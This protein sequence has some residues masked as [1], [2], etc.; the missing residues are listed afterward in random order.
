MALQGKVHKLEVVLAVVELILAAAAGL[1]AP[2]PAE[3]EGIMDPRQG[4][5][6]H[7]DKRSI[8]RLHQIMFITVFLKVWHHRLEVQIC[9]V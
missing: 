6:E 8:H 9:R 3:A 1:V 7:R 2:D 5:E 4:L